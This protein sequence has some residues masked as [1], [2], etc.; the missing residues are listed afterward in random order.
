MFISARNSGVKYFVA[1]GEAW[2]RPLPF[3]QVKSPHA[4]GVAF[5][6]RSGDVVSGCAAALFDVSAALVVSAEGFCAMI[7][8]TAASAR[9]AAVKRMRTCMA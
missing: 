8:D 2:V 1:S 4:K 5:E 9:Q 7:G 3:T 6:F